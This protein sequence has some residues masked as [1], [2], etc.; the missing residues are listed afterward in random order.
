MFSHFSGS[1][2]KK[3]DDKIARCFLDIILGTCWRIFAVFLVRA[4]SHSTVIYSVFVPLA[5]K[6]YFLQ[7]AENCVNTSL[8]ARH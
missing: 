7:H 3:T 1:G 2:V 4:K 8:F 6:K 5:C